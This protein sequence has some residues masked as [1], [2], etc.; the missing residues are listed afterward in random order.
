MIVYA[1]SAFHF[2]RA[3]RSTVKFCIVGTTGSLLGTLLE[4]PATGPDTASS[5]DGRAEQA[6]TMNAAHAAIRCT[7]L[8]VSTKAG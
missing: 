5:L 6:E 4:A 8:G 3:T 1:A 7:E 2:Q